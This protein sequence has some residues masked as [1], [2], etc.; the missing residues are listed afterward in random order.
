[1]AKQTPMRSQGSLTTIILVPKVCG[2]NKLS[3]RF[4]SRRRSVLAC[5]TSL[6]TEKRAY[7]WC[8]DNQITRRVL[9]WP[10]QV[11]QAHWRK[12]ERQVFSAG[13]PLLAAS[14]WHASRRVQACRLITL[15][16]GPRIMQFPAHSSKSG[17][18]GKPVTR[19]TAAETDPGQGEPSQW[20]APT[21]RCDMSLDGAWEG[22]QHPGGASRIS[23]HWR[24]EIRSVG[25]P[26]ATGLQHVP[27][28]G[29]CLGRWDGGG[30]C[31]W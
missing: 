31:P 22:R 16:A 27:L 26:A 5:S 23:I 30:L 17:P 14:K 13:S 18:G 15:R 28:Q 10:R 25:Q 12:A 4:L 20:T 11:S 1:M 3:S 6:F 19:I 9:G 7:R 2:S 8:H 21:G 29:V 24:R